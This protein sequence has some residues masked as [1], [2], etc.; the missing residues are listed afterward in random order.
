VYN[1]TKESISLQINFSPFTIHY[2]NP[3][4]GEIIKSMI[5]QRESGRIVIN[6]LLDGPEVIWITKE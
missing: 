6:K 1:D 5:N 3:Q 2:I 4:T